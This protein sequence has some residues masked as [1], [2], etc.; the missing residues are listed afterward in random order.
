MCRIAGYFRRKGEYLDALELN[1]IMRRMDLDNDGKI[2]Y[3]EFIESVLPYQKSSYQERFQR[4]E[5]KRT[6]ALNSQPPIERQ[7]RRTSPKP[8]RG[9]L[10]EPSPLRA[11]SRPPVDSSPSYS[12]LRFPMSSTREKYYSPSPTRRTVAYPITSTTPGRDSDIIYKKFLLDLE[13]REAKKRRDLHELQMRM[14]AQKTLE[15]HERQKRLERIEIERE[16]EK[17]NEER[18]KEAEKRLENRLLEK[19]RIRREALREEIE[20]E[21]QQRILADKQWADRLRREELLK[22]YERKKK[23]EEN[24]AYE[25]QILEEYNKKKALEADKK[26]AMEAAERREAIYLDM[27]RKEELQDS[28]KRQRLRD[29]EIREASRE[30]E[31]LRKKTALERE[32]DLMRAKERAHREYQLW[33]IRRENERMDRQKRLNNQLDIEKEVRRAAQLEKE[34]QRVREEVRLRALRREME[35]DR[36]RQN[37]EW[38]RS[39]LERDLRSKERQREEV[40]AR[41]EDRPRQISTGTSTKE[42]KKE[43]P[44]GNI[45]AQEDYQV[46]EETEEP[47]IVDQR[48]DTEDSETEIHGDMFRTPGEAKLESSNYSGQEKE[49]P[50]AS[51]E[52][53]KS[54]MMYATPEKKEDVANVGKA[55]APKMSMTE[56]DEPS[57]VGHIVKNRAGKEKIEDIPEKARLQ[58]S[59]D[60][61]MA[62]KE[63]IY[64]EQKLEEAK[65]D[66]S[67]CNDFSLQNVFKVLDVGTT[68]KITLKNLEEGLKK[69]GIYPTSDE[70]FLF[71]KSFDKNKNESLRFSEFSNAFLPKNPQFAQPLKTRAATSMVLYIYIYIYI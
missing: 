65:E 64:N 26:K 28:I 53:R 71:M 56:F 50:P 60:M 25:K 40:L 61:F 32:I 59:N 8:Q 55:E 15:R 52:E 10:G 5:P 27:K 46:D 24:A 7:E 41:Y 33:L 13:I 42:V 29:M 6:R 18:K 51:E 4:S 1:N 31:K 38:R 47:K 2:S 45:V 63:Q 39:E 35:I 70:R 58:I 23:E 16:L 21:Q 57:T 19:E 11:R 20:R 66:L 48:E 3:L 9:E 14:E 17:R 49:T 34:L 22:E 44:R 12:A 67:M 69:Y 30:R 43:A 36:Q 68:G 54:A 62:F 37:I